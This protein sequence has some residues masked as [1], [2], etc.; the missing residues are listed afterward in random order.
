MTLQQIL[1]YCNYMLSKNQKGNTIDPDEISLALQA[2]NI[3]LFEFWIRQMLLAKQLPLEGQRNIFA[4][5]P[6][7]K[8][9]NN[10]NWNS[11]GNSGVLDLPA[12]FRQGIIA[13]CTI[14]IPSTEPNT[15]QLVIKP[16]DLFTEEEFEMLRTSVLSQDFSSLPAGV[17]RGNKLQ[18][19]GKNILKISMVYYRAPTTP[20]YDYY[21]KN[22]EVKYLPPT[23]FVV[24]IGNGYIYNVWRQLV[25]YDELVDT[26]VYYPFYSPIP[27]TR[28]N[29]RSVELEWDESFHLAIANRVLE[30]M[31]LN[32]RDMKVTQYTQGEQA[33]GQ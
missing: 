8:F 10:K 28:V 31:A 26:G 19:L 17:I 5:S 22:D 29:S 21:M 32:I 3:D 23:Y 1:D 6:L 13:T 18:V 27:A 24:S 16:F 7:K 33:Q 11:V 15:E 2:S 4:T 30:R 12:G 9:T 14:P 20:F 25:D